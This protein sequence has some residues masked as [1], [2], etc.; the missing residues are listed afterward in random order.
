MSAALALP[1]A[2]APTATAL[3]AALTAAVRKFLDAE[4]AVP[5]LERATADAYD[6]M[7]AATAAVARTKDAAT[8]AGTVDADALA[9]AAL[10]GKP[11][12]ALA[13]GREARTAV[14][15]AEE[16]LT[17]ATRVRDALATKT[18]EAKTSLGYAASGARTAAL[19]VVQA[20]NTATLAAFVTETARL[21]IELQ[22]R[23]AAIAWLRRERLVPY[24]DATISEIISF[25]LSVDPGVPPRLDPGTLAGRWEKLV[26]NLTRDHKAPATL[27]LP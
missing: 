25:R 13:S 14:V 1:I 11:A 15:D 21:Q 8:K 12:P 10:A 3:R 4:A 16:A 18:E 23:L 9:E 19:A 5:K 27:P 20:N 22:G 2:A 24:L 17:Q 7:L 6:A 26:A